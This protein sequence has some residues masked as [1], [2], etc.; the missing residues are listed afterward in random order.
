MNRQMLAIGSALLLAGC[1]SAGTQVS[2]RQ[3]GQFQK[4]VTTEQQVVAKLGQPTTTTLNAD[5]TR[6]D[7]YTFTRATPNAVDFVPIVGLF[8]GGAHGRTTNVSFN[9]NKGGV[10]TGYKSSSSKVDVHT[11]IMN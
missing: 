6:V 4:G 8:A 1:V 10:L 11:G 3:A 7:T 9:F 2:E 5:G